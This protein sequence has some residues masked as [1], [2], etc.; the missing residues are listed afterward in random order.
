MEFNVDNRDLVEHRGRLFALARSEDWNEPVR[1]RETPTLR[2]GI[3][4]QRIA[5]MLPQFWNED[6]EEVAMAL[7]QFRADLV[8]EIV[9]CNPHEL[10]FVVRTHRILH[11]NSSTRERAR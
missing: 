1:G 8:A 9:S 4:V 11:E 2:L 6:P 5:S 10:G 7:A 3:L